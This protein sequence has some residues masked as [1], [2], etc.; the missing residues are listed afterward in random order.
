MDGIERSRLTK[1]GKKRQ[2]HKAFFLGDL[3]VLARQ[4][5]GGLPW[6][7]GLGVG[8]GL[9]SLSP[10][11]QDRQ[12]N[13]ETCR[14]KML[15]KGRIVSLRVLR[16][17]W[18]GLDLAWGPKGYVSQSDAENAEKPKTYGRRW[19]RGGRVFSGQSWRFGF[20]SPRTNDS[21]NLAASSTVMP[22]ATGVR[23][24]G[25]VSICRP[26]TPFRT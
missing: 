8:S 6:A 23:H 26:T 1:E 12:E 13:L 18:Q 19:A 25:A 21:A 17:D 14:V 3:G 16:L 24:V 4:L 10:R 20:G 7:G 15:G 11:R 22:V 2:K 5:F 9:K